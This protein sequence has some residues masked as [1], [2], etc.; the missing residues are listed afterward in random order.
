MQS[1]PSWWP[2]RLQGFCWRRWT[3]T[4]C[5]RI[6]VDGRVIHW[7]VDD[8]LPARKLGYC[9]IYCQIRGLEGIEGEEKC[10]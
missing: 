3:P 8:P 9:Q 1:S 10:F 6:S 5:R 4:V 2:G 7:R